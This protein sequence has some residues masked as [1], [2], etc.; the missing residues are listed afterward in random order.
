LTL[1]T[2]QLLLKII[3]GI[4]EISKEI[5]FTSEIVVQTAFLRMWARNFT[6]EAQE[7]V[8]KIKENLQVQ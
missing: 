3:C 1:K 6:N 8:T 5:G 2:L 7:M 4:K